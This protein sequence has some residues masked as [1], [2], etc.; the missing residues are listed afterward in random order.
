MLS[1]FVLVPLGLG[2]AGR[3][4]AG[5][6]TPT[7]GR[8]RLAAG[9]AAV[10]AALAFLPDRSALA[11]A[12]TVPWLAVGLTA[13]VIGAGRFLS[14][15]RLD[16]TIGIDAALA[17]LTVGAG[18]LTI[19]RAGTNPLGFSDAIVQLTAVH[20]HYAGFALPLVVGL[21]ARQSGRG[22]LVPAWVIVGVPLTAAGI[23]VG[24]TLEWVAATVMATGG[25]ATAVLVARTA[26]TERR[27]TRGLLLV[28]AVSLTA[29]M[30]LALGWA[31]SIRFGWTYPDLTEMARWHG[32]LNAIGFGFAALTGLHLT[33]PTEGAPVEHLALHVGRPPRT[34]LSAIGAAAADTEPTSPIGLLQRPVPDGYRHD[35]WTAPLPHGFDPARLALQGWIGHGTAGITIT[36]PPP[37][38][39]GETVAMAIP[40]GPIW[41]TAAARIVDVVDEPDRYGFTYATLPHHPEDG[42][43]SFIITRDGDSDATCTVTAV[44]RTG[45]YVSRVLPPLTRFPQRRAIGRYLTGIAS[46]MPETKRER[47]R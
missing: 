41:V 17:F 46:W 25:L 36:D 7:L 11:A 33:K 47:V 40:V 12:M 9:P 5:P 13:G 28:A 20:F 15:R 44:W 45:T 6:T 3:P 26:L 32:T 42:E 14:R 23:T 31:W 30:V 37:I 8:L 35:R 27:A 10:L 38:A 19:S 34:V 43:E 1:P 4:E 16:P 21:A 29:G 24:G 39:V 2:L 18:W 22:P